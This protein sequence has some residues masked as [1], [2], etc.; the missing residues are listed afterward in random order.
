MVSLLK[1]FY[2][3]MSGRITI[4]GSQ[5]IVDI[6]HRRAVSLMQQEPA[7]F[8]GTI[9]D[10]VSL[11]VGQDDSGEITIDDTTIKTALRAADA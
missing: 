9:R 10:N 5:D 3:P 2:D 8:Q 7:L 4:E 11:G 1:R 6:N